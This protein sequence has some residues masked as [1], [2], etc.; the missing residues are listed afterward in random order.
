M[1]APPLREAANLTAVPVNQLTVAGNA[2][3]PAALLSAF[4]FGDA[5]RNGAALFH[6]L[7]HDD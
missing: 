4:R 5:A 2:C 7:F 6:A 1:A 3:G